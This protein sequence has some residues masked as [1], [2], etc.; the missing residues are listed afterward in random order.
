MTDITEQ[1]EQQPEQDKEFDARGR[2][3]KYDPAKLDDVKRL[4]LLGATDDE[5]AEFLG[6]HRATFYDWKNRHPDFV[7]AIWSGKQGAD[8]LVAESL[9]RSATTGDTGASK[10]WLI[11]R[12][13]DL[14]REKSETKVTVTTDQVFKIGDT[15]IKF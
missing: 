7:D 11:N 2:P 8:A 5:I 12:R 1:P 3:T 9:F 4:C 13:P 10:M 14:W 15:E 6:I